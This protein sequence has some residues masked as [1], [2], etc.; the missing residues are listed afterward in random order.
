MTGPGRVD[1]RMSERLDEL[2][3]RQDTWVT[4]DILQRY[5][6]DG[7]W[8]D[9]SFVHDLERHAAERP[10]ALAIIDE[11]GRRTSYGEYERR[12]RA[13]AL[14]LLDLGLTPGDRLAMQLPN[15]SEF[16]VTLMAC[17]R[18]RIIPVFLHVVYD[19]HDLD[20]VLNL[21]GARALVVPV[22]FKGREFVPLAR[23]MR[24]RVAV[25]EH[26]IVVGGDGADGLLSFEA[27]AG[28]GAATST[29]GHHDLD[30]LR[31]TGADPFFIMFTSGTTGRPKAELH[32]HANNLF[33]IRKFEQ[34]QK[35]PRN[36]QWII[37][38]P[39]AHLTGLGLGVLSA[40]HRGAAFTLLTG[41]DTA[42]CVELLERDRPTFLL[43]AAPMLIDLARFADL[44]SR[45]VRSL[46][47]I[48]YAGAPCPAE[49]LSALNTQL[50]VD[51]SAFYGYTEAGVTHMTRPGD[52][53]SITSRSI[54]TVLDGVRMRLVD[55]EGREVE[56]PGEGELW[57]CGPNFVVGYFGQPDITTKM[58]TEDGWFRSA[59]IVRFD[60]DGYG[61]FVSRRDDLINRG[62]YKID[63]REI[64]E[65]LYEH[66]RVGQAAVV[67]MPD[68]RLGQR[69]AVFV[70]PKT[71]GDTVALA[72][73]TAFLADKGLS[74]TKWPE[75]VEMLESF[76]MTSTGKFMRYSL[77]DR[78]ARLR[79]QR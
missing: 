28:A 8:T 51:I 59:D 39:I 49:T 22:D 69:A 48:C 70:V 42:R 54:G 25:L 1:D 65:L 17:A 24:E 4:R 43:G 37:V 71:P 27:M 41:W 29:A 20:Y 53:I 35:F 31:P 7:D 74:R 16:C 57:S 10:D 46:R 36:A 76:P 63:P 72:D 14:S 56:L 73:L 79:P 21:T 19:E 34:G 40:L 50:D 61:Y 66:P 38:T 18:A 5:V 77:R 62:G 47:T 23:T 9:Q 2:A 44:G 11:D 15:S 13:L 75:A 60:T 55:D 64:E 78:A 45:D 3:A 33:W 52:P 32:T 58:F 6:D 68:E 67:A 30:A 12:T 26:L